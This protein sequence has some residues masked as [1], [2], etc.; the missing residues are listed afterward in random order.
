MLESLPQAI[1]DAFEKQDTPALQAA[2]AGLPQEEA[3]YHF[4][5]V[6]DSGLW[7]P[8]RER[9]EVG[10]GRMKVT[11]DMLQEVAMVA[12]K[13]RML[14]MRQRTALS[15]SVELLA[16]DGVPGLMSVYR[17]DR[18]LQ[19]FLDKGSGAEAAGKPEAGESTQVAIPRG[20]FGTVMA[21]IAGMLAV[22]VALYW[23]AS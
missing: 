18:R 11:Y 6:V 15:R 3:K 12:M 5:R 4:Q 23:Q 16:W 9:E 19:A 20:S 1:K 22:L 7:V 14:M 17:P 8:G 13:T 21:V 2:F 10:E